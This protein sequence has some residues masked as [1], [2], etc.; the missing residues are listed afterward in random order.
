[1]SSTALVVLKSATSIFTLNMAPVNVSEPSASMAYFG[2]TI[3]EEAVGESS[4]SGADI[5][6]LSAVFEHDSSGLLLDD[7]VFG[8]P[9][10]SLFPAPAIDA[11]E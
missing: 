1:M 11:V 6:A 3:P 2:S 5:S 8:F 10:G 4:L 7:P 9:G